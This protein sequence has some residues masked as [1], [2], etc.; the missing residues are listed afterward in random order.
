MEEYSSVIDI[1][2][3]I[4]IGVIV[5]RDSTLSNFINSS[6]LTP[7][8]YCVSLLSYSPSLIHLQLTT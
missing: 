5:A 8:F 3:I 7:L 1:I 2:D 4:V 6:L